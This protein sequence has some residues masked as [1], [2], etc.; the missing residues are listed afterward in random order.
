MRVYGDLLD[1]A[2][3]EDRDA[4]VTLSQELGY[5]TGEEDTVRQS[6][7]C[8]SATADG[9]VSTRPWSMPT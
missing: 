3:A 6:L 2:I 7:L 8:G 4:A 1:A 5:L 9:T